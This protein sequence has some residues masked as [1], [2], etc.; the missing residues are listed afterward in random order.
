MGGERK[1]TRPVKVGKLIIG[2]GFPISVQ[3][4]WKAPLESRQDDT[5]V[6]AGIRSLED[7]GCEILRFSV[8][9]IET[10]EIVGRL[11]LSLDLPLVADIHFDYR[12]ALRCLDFPIAKIR[13]NPGNIGEA[14]KVEEV[15][16]KAKD[17]SIPLRIGINAGSLPRSLRK[18]KYKALAMLK[19]AEIE[20]EV[21]NKMGFD[22]TIFSLKASDVETT[23]EA[24]LLFSEKYDFPLHLGVTE[25][26]PLIQ[27]IV[28][29]TLAL[30]RLLEKGVGDTVRVSLS[31]SPENEIT[32]GR[33]ILR[34]SGRR[35]IGVDIISCPTCGRTV[36]DV[37]KFLEVVHNYIHKLNKPI[38]I[39]VMGCPVNGPGEA[40]NADLGLTGAGRYAVFFKKGRVIRRVKIEEAADI[41]K[42]EVEKL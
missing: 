12:I 5:A 37:K 10:A 25:A 19:A 22:Q 7:S 13:L 3:T 38:S 39:A 20:L 30:S 41:F 6:L 1:K 2:G 28:K 27:G 9:E 23:V 8:P 14:W 33:A 18:E 29:N 42:E 36:F 24:N 35:K 31:D 16:R 21:L 4:M 26:G 40:R 17:K 11:S 15:I 32:A 34:I